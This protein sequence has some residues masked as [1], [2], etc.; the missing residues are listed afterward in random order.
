[1]LGDVF[2]AKLKMS[3]EEFSKFAKQANI[4]PKTGKKTNKTNQK[5]KNAVKKR[6]KQFGTTLEKSALNAP[7][8]AVSGI[9]TALSIGRSYRAKDYTS[10][11]TKNTATMV[12]TRGERSLNGLRSEFTS[13]GPSNSD[14]MPILDEHWSTHLQARGSLSTPSVKTRGSLTTKGRISPTLPE[15]AP[16]LLGNIQMPIGTMSVRKKRK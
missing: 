14:R 6:A 12:G 1:M 16:S 11:I 15:M 5:I 4:D 10:H 2:M 9:K 7:K 13:R 8:S 3:E